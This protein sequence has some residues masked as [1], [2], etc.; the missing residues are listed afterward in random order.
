MSCL[1]AADYI[2]EF[3][4]FGTELYSQPDKTNS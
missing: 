3:F 1:L 4:F 2:G